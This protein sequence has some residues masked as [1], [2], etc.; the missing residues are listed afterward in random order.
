MNNSFTLIQI[1]KREGGVDCVSATG[2][3]TTII[4]TV[5]HYDHRNPTYRSG[6]L[7]VY[8]SLDQ[9]ELT[10]TIDKLHPST[11]IL[12]ETVYLGL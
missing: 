11:V 3:D 9:V 2:R 12:E 1:P 5:K 7:P 10:L 8:S 6:T 4:Q